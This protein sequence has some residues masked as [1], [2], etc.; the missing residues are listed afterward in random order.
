MNTT[1]ETSPLAPAAA[2]LLSAIN[3]ACARIAPTWPLDRFI[4]VNPYWGHLERP[5]AAAAAH[6]AAL[7]GG[8]LLMS[9]DG[10]RQEWQAGRVGRQHLQAAITAAGSTETVDT[11]LASLDARPAL[12]ARLPL[13]TDLVDAHR[14]L[15][16]AMAWRDY[17]T[18]H[19]SQSCAGFFDQGQAAWG[20]DRSG[21]LYPSWLRQSAHDLGP[22]MLMGYP[23]FS[24]RL[25]RLPGE[26][27]A[28]I[29]AAL[30][31]LQVPAA[32]HEAYFSALLMS[33]NG[34]AS[35]CAYQ[36]W[37]ARL[38]QHDDEQIVHLLAV[39]LAWEWL[40]HDGY[41]ALAV[42]NSLASA[43]RGSDE[44]VSQA[45]RAQQADWLW[46]AALERSYQA[47]LC[48]GLHRAPGAPAEP[49]AAAA[50]PAVQA[51]FCIDVRSEVYRRKSR[52]GR[53]NC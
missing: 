8:T 49:A 9:R 52:P 41:P 27:R 47:P 18:H 2:K 1:L 19:I 26:P 11:L 45:Q 5:I 43:W 16:H 31:A 40:L 34:W 37:Q 15:G 29:A 36:R 17:I 4:A 51:V 22:G 38:E 33:I 28:L 48:Q 7:S 14:D 50:S 20:P 13:A 6:L 46:Q 23:G 53:G 32:A 3:S 42:A 39:R 21:G 10:F 30:Q 35:W 44:C 24:L 25:A 12:P